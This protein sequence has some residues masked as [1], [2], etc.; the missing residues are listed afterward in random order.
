LEN[1]E[2][3]ARA[4]II[5]NDKLL[6]AH[7]IG[8]SNT[9]L[10]GGHVEA[11]EFVIDALQRELYEEMSLSCSVLEPIGVLEY[12]FIDRHNKK[13]HEVN[14]IYKTMIIE[15]TIDSSESILEFWWSDSNDL[16][17]QNLLPTP[18]NEMLLE[19]FKYR[20]PIFK[21]MKEIY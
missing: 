7:K 19:W 14:F 21:S 20:K 16:P 4:V 18:L 17:N 6:L 2:L 12:I 15:G 8:E 11:G 5:K 10:P 9:F 1:I 3:I 13:H